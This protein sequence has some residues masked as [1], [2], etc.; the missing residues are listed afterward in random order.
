MSEY[1]IPKING[2]RNEYFRKP[3]KVRQIILPILF[4]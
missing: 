2:I 4:V 1:I 3:N